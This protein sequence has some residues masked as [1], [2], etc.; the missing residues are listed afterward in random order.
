M[1]DQVAGVRLVPGILEE[2]LAQVLDDI[3]M[4]RRQFQVFRLCD[5][6]GQALAPIV[7]IDQ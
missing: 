1:L 5:V 3:P 6:L 7:R 2:F 4:A